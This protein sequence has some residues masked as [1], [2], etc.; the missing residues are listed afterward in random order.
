MK[1]EHHQDGQELCGRAVAHPMWRGTGPDVC[2]LDACG[3]LAYIT[4]H[5]HRLGIV[6]CACVHESGIAILRSKTTFSK[7]FPSV[8]NILLYQR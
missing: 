5:G 6:F 8:Y 2:S 4:L 1:L 7:V 3:A